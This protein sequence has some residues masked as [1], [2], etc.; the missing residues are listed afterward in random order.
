MSRNEKVS[1]RIRTKQVIERDETVSIS[2]KDFDRLQ[3]MKR[4]GDDS[5]LQCEVENLIDL[6]DPVTDCFKIE[7]ELAG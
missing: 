6:F 7:I 1:V 4:N 3:R 5:G 2:R